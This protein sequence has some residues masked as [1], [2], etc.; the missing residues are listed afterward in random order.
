MTGVHQE[1]G[2]T[3]RQVFLLLHTKQVIKASLTITALIAQG[4][5]TS[6]EAQAERIRLTKVMKVL[7]L[8]QFYCS[9]AFFGFPR[10]AYARRVHLYAIRVNT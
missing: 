4:R 6:S 3:S 1:W 7:A 5:T 2:S 9:V 8:Y 10:S